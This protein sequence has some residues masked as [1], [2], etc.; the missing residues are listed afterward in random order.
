MIIVRD[1]VEV[2]LFLLTHNTTAYFLLKISAA[3]SHKAYLS[4]KRSVIFCTS[5]SSFCLTPVMTYN[6]VAVNRALRHCIEGS[7]FLHTCTTIPKW[8]MCEKLPDNL[9]HIK[10]RA[11]LRT[12]THTHTYAHNFWTHQ[13]TN[14]RGIHVFLVT[15]LSVSKPVTITTP[16]FVSELKFLGWQQSLKCS[17]V[18]IGFLLSFLSQYTVI[19]SDVWQFI[20][21]SQ[22]YNQSSSSFHLEWSP[23]SIHYYPK[24]FPLIESYALRLKVAS[25]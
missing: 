4:L 25:A 13:D 14:W 2:T 19:M 21:S 17:V 22:F 6:N 11:F 9:K 18:T 24:L 16:L 20:R 7:V 15:V 1:V 12:H 3:L 10:L 5:A 8:H 23:Y